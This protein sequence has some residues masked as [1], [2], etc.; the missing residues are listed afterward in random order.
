MIIRLIVIL[1]SFSL[2]F[3][4]EKNDK[5]KKKKKIFS[6]TQSTEE[7]L[8]LLEKS[9]GLLKTNY[10][11]SINESEL[12]L[13]GIKGLLNPLDPY[14]KLL[15]E[16]SK[17]NY[18]LLKTGKYGGI[19]VQIGLRRDT[20]TVL[21]IY[22]NS[23]AYS[24]GLNVGDNIM[25]VD[26]TSTEGLSLKES[27]ALIKGDLDSIVT[28]NVYRSSTKEK[29]KFEF[30]RSNIAIEHVPYWGLNKEKTGYIRVTRFSK[31]SGKDFKKALKDLQDRGLESLIIDLRSNSGGLLSSAISILDNLTER[32]DTLL[33]QKGKTNRSNKVW[34]SRRSPIIS[35]DIP[36]IVLINKKS[37]SAS[38]IVA[39]TIQDLDRGIILGEKSFGKGLVQHLY[40]LNDSTTLKI[41]TA[42]FYLPSGRIIQKQDYLDNGFLTDGLDKRDS[43]FVT[44]KGRLVKGGGGIIPDLETE[45][46]K[47]TSF[48]NALWK[49]KVFLTFASDY[50][51]KNPWLRKKIEKDLVIPNRVL[52]SFK[53]FINNY[54]LVFNVSGEVDLEKIKKKMDNNP[55]SISKY[56]Y[57]VSTSSKNSILNEIDKYFEKIKKLQFSL[58]DNQT[59]IKNGLLREFCR[60]FFN[61]KKRIE[62]SL[63]ND[64]SYNKAVEIFSEES[65]EYN[66]ILEISTI[67]KK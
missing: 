67:N 21:S 5:I 50:A 34:T 54:N 47:Y 20:L 18:D 7:Y 31:N 10:V 51:P 64:I 32:G 11:D 49:E 65:K 39:G 30:T 53:K 3:S 14:T 15:M 63:I 55:I 42:K 28:L 26:S 52:Q 24:E 13:S 57:N 66:K 36:I 2:L 44:R 8:D 41:T 16:E 12:I 62:V 58:P 61:D 25:K 45:P 60:V 6:N 43:I 17:E 56:S 40:D 19:G 38:E 48:V 46:N 35:M 9:L 4:Q 37:A 23:P 29:I 59:Q 33:I 22:E 27:S 1:F